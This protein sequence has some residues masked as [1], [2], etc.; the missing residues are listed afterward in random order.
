MTWAVLG[1]VVAPYRAKGFTL[2]QTHTGHISQSI[3]AEWA[4]ARLKQPRRARIRWRLAGMVVRR[5]PDEVGVDTTSVMVMTVNK[6]AEAEFADET[7]GKASRRLGVV[8]G[9]CRSGGQD[10]GRQRQR[11]KSRPA[12]S[13]L[14]A[15]P[16]VWP[17]RILPKA[18]LA[19]FRLAQSLSGATSRTASS[20]VA[21]AHGAS[22][23]RKCC[24]PAI[25]PTAQGAG[26]TQ[27]GIRAG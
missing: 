2:V 21:F 27:Q 22:A 11:S 16:H 5:R 8:S 15:K 26:Q 9:D 4:S 10:D 20:L 6:R 7:G 12:E 13:R 17:A 1:L 23:G 19:K 24:L 3:V 14:G 25:F 18:Y